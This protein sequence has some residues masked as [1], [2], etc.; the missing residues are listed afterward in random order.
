M[1]DAP[2]PPQGPAGQAPA[3]PAPGAPASSAPGGP[4]PAAALQPLALPLPMGPIPAAAAAAGLPPAAMLMAV[5]ARRR[6]RRP[7]RRPRPRPQPPFRQHMASAS[8][9]ADAS[10]GSGE[11]TFVAGHVCIQR[12]RR[13]PS[14]GP[15][16]RKF[17]R[18][19]GADAR[20]GRAVA[21]ATASSRAP[22]VVEPSSSSQAGLHTSRAARAA[23]RAP[24]ARYTR[25]SHDSNAG[26]GRPLEVPVC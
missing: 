3:Q 13:P 4:I 24:D 19:R 18:V 23:R 21:A 8:P 14:F 22:V 26:L 17:A 9:N 6:P 20:L 10:R 7:A 2:P 25:T 15:N 5:P 16:L 12:P 11:N 1:A